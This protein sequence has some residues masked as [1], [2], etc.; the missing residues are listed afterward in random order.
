MHGTTWQRLGTTGVA[1][2]LSGCMAASPF[3]GSRTADPEPIY[4]VENRPGGFIIST[5]YSSRQADRSATEAACRS[6]LV[7]NANDLAKS[8]GRTIEP[9]DAQ[10]VRATL[11]HDASTGIT[12]CDASA[13]ATWARTSDRAP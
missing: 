6:G 9:I 8:Q 4:M 7:R 2:I 1:L 13:S 5:S 10:R 3:G 11:S 12:R